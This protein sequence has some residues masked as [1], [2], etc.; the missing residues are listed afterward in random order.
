MQVRPSVVGTRKSPLE[1]DIHRASRV[2]RVPLSVIQGVQ[3]EAQR[4]LTA[5]RAPMRPVGQAPGTA[6][7]KVECPVNELMR[8]SLWFIW[9]SRAQPRQHL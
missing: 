3:L 8:L 1:F 6:G 4:F 9:R 7:M 2:A 5:R